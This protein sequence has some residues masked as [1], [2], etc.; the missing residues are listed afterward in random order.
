[1]PFAFCCLLKSA[2]LKRGKLVEHSLTELLALSRESK[3]TSIELRIHALNIMKKLFQDSDLKGDLDFYVSDAF[4]SSIKG[5]TSEEWGVRNSSLQL[6]TALSNRTVGVKPTYN[7]LE[8]F[9]K[10]PSLL[11]FIQNELNNFDESSFNTMYPP[12]YPIVLL[13]SRL[14]PFD[15]KERSKII[16]KDSMKHIRKEELLSLLPIMD[17]AGINT[18]YMGRVMTA[19]AILPF[20][21]IDDIQTYCVEGI[22]KLPQYFNVN[23]NMLHYQLTKYFHLLTSYN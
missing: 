12:L 20:M 18:N 9:L 5:F 14:L 8:F 19:K 10:C 23:N 7:L 21:E 1:M 3:E 13:F 22:E 17:R 6:F 4:I 15:M 11:E 2:S 16:P